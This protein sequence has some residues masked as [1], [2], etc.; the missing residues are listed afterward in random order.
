MSGKNHG[1]QKFVTKEGLIRLVLKRSGEELRE[2]L[3]EF[4]SE[5][6]EDIGAGLDLSDLDKISPN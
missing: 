6:P 2:I 5:M 4:L 3:D 1:I